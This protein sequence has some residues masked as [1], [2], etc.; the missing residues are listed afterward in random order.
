[1]KS[2]RQLQDSFFKST[3][4]KSTEFRRIKMRKHNM[5]TGRCLQNMWQ[6]ILFQVIAIA[7]GFFFLESLRNTKLSIDKKAEKAI[8]YYFFTISLLSTVFF[9]FSTRLIDT[10]QEKDG[11][12]FPLF[13]VIHWREFSAFYTVMSI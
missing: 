8:C 13:I 7:S 5:F 6:V 12:H 10:L 1:M 4:R 9:I 3:N 11:Y 2:D